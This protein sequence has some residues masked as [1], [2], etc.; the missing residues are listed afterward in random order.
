MHSELS[1]LIADIQEVEKGNFIFKLWRSSDIQAQ[2]EEV[3]GKISD[4]MV[5]L[6]VSTSTTVFWY[7]CSRNAWQTKQNTIAHAMIEEILK[8]RSPNYQLY[9]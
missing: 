5:N 4:A 7:Q 3:K 8:V 9:Q 2:L 6:Q 1:P